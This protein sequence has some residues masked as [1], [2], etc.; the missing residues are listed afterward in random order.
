[1]TEKNHTI[2]AV[3]AHPDD[4]IGAGSTMAYYSDQGMRVVLCCAT[5]G[6]AAT[7]FCDGCAT[8][9]TLAAVRT[10]EL[11]CACDHLGIQE[12][13]WL[14]WPDGK[15]RELAR[16]E[17]V[18]ELVALIREIRPTVLLTHPENGLYPHPD[19]LAVW[20]MVRA[21]YDAAADEA[22]YAGAGPA[23]QTPRL[24]TRAMPQS[25]F[26][27]APGLKDFRV[28]LNGEL[29][30]FMGTPDDEI[31]VTMRVGEWVPR[32]MAAWNCHISQHNPKGFSSVMPDGLREEMA[33]REQFILVAGAPLP[34]GIQSDL[35]VGLEEGDT[36]M[37]E[38]LQ[39]HEQQ[40]DAA[41]DEPEVS[42]AFIRLLNAELNRHV[43]LAEVLRSYER[44]PRD[45]RHGALYRQLSATEQE[46]IYLLARRLR[47]LDAGAGKTEPDPTVIREAKRRDRPDLRHEFLLNR[48]E[49]AY[50]RFL[51]NARSATVEEERA[52]WEELAALARGAVELMKA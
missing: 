52:V 32:R 1:M 33:A 25:I 18:G 11:R 20:E 13:R 34:E 17:A 29:L 2:L 8:P 37:V 22:Q 30:P 40:D 10:Q 28:E 51:D 39:G 35:F 44:D 38:G 36:Y 14:D 26:E 50:G 3:F 9:D 4:E 5:R 48:M 23:W 31:D 21:A 6:E 19:H 45:L 46:V 16:E 24:F 47:R 41:S 27:R 7:I 42:E 49:V 43:S 15:I 12:L